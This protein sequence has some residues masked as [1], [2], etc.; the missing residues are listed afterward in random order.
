MLQIGDKIKIVYME[1]EPQYTNKEGVV[2][3][4]QR[5]PVDGICYRGTWGGCS[6][7]P[8]K[9]E[10]KI[11]WLCVNIVISGNLAVANHY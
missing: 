5:D 3:D 8:N 11:I 9:D 2:T 10:F 4:I 7:Y 1:G 6:V